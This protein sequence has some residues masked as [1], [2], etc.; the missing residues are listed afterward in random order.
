MSFMA[1]ANSAISILYL[2]MF[3]CWRH[4]QLGRLILTLVFVYFAFEYLLG[5]S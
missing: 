5:C 4:T 1:S 3:L 2:G